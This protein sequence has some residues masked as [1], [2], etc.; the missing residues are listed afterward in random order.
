MKI[1]PV[2]ESRIISRNL[3]LA[4]ARCLLGVLLSALS[5]TATH[6]VLGETEKASGS[7]SE[8][9]DPPKATTAVL[10][11][12]RGTASVT[13][14]LGLLTFRVAHDILAPLSA[15]ERIGGARIARADYPAAFAGTWAQEGELGGWIS[16]T[17]DPPNAT[18]EPTTF[19]VE[20]A[21]FDNALTREALPPVTGDHIEFGMA[22]I[23]MD[24]PLPWSRVRTDRR[25]TLGWEST[26]VTQEAPS[27]FSGVSGVVDV[28][29]FRADIVARG[30]DVDARSQPLQLEPL[31]LD[32]PRIYDGVPNY[33]GLAGIGK[34]YLNYITDFSVAPAPTTGKLVVRAEVSGYI[35]EAQVYTLPN[36]AVMKEWHIPLTGV[37]VIDRSNSSGLT[38]V[39]AV[40]MPFGGAGMIIDGLGT[41]RVKV[42][43]GKTLYA[44]PGASQQQDPNGAVDRTQSEPRPFAAVDSEFDRAELIA[45]AAV[46]HTLEQTLDFDLRTSAFRATLDPN[47]RGEQA[48]ALRNVIDV[49]ANK[50]Y[51]DA[52]TVPAAYVDS[53]PV[54]LDRARL[55][56]L[57]VLPFRDGGG[58]GAKLTAAFEEYNQT[59]STFNRLYHPGLFV[60]AV[61]DVGEGLYA[62]VEHQ[63][64]HGG[65]PPGGRVNSN[66]VFRALDG[67]TINAYPTQYVD[68]AERGP[69]RLG[70]VDRTT[71]FSA[72]SG[73]FVDLAVGDHRTNS[74]YRTATRIFGGKISVLLSPAPLLGRVPDPNM[75]ISGRKVTLIQEP[76][77]N[78]PSSPTTLTV[79]RVGLADGP[80]RTPPVP[81]PLGEPCGAVAVTDAAVAD[82]PPQ[83]D[84]REAWFDADRSSIYVSL[85]LAEVP[86]LPVSTTGDR[87]AVTWRSNHDGYTARATLLPS[88][89]WEFELGDLTFG[90][91]FKMGDIEGEVQPGPNGVIRMAIPRDWLEYEDGTLLRDTAI[92][93]YA[94]TT[95]VPIDHAPEGSSFAYGLGNDHVITSCPVPPVGLT[96]VASRKLHGGVSFDVVLPL[97]GNPGIECRS[98]GANGDYTLVFSFA[99]PLSSVGN[100]SVTNGTGSVTNSDIDSSDDH[101][102]IVNLTGVTNAQV[103]TVSLTNV[104][105]SAGNG[106]ASVSTSMGVLLADVSANGNVSNT[107]VAAVKGQI[108]SPVTGSNFRNDVNANGIVSNTDVSVTKAQV[109]TTLP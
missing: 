98:G 1:T 18:Y 15:S 93:A 17:T 77:P 3:F 99:N 70:A 66:V 28:I 106:S 12:R 90:G 60:H 49:R 23:P 26:V 48:L 78:M 51:A 39:A 52:L 38:P 85:R 35:P 102:Y 34:P 86:A 8:L 68:L 67:R 107:D 32:L 71:E 14:S 16:P 10:D 42:S 72:A 44:Q 104:I 89:E 27:E 65:V 75:A 91:Y 61:Y 31:V 20:N 25:G 30:G 74:D 73:V 100:A 59:A 24:T 97:A 4:T 37:I 58:F 29:M 87:Y 69:A 63:L 94:G 83:S 55:M 88:G 103:I 36:G 50:S 9:S 43:P 105:D 19:L 92:Y 81:P 79:L 22:V 108:S 56:D 95:N 62:F 84:V 40:S 46:N 33:V 47:Y 54:L 101:N 21:Y 13:G 45:A 80:V 53:Q 11:V 76:P 57:R 2:F 64:F 5:F 7:A 6:D 82:A 109:T 96:A 41:R